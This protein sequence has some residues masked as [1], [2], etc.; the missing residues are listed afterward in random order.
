MGAARDFNYKVALASGLR[1]LQGG[2]L[3]QAEEQFR[4]LVAKFPA[5]D[6]GYRGLAKV[7]VELGDPKAALATLRQGAA[8]CAKATERPAAIALLREAVAL[9]PLDVTSHRHLAATLALAGQHGAAIDEVA[10]YA[11]AATAAGRLDRAQLE[12]AY[13]VERFPSD[14]ALHELRRR[15]G[16]SVAV[17]PVGPIDA[18]AV[19][20]ETLEIESDEADSVATAAASAPAPVELPPPVGEPAGTEERAAMLIGTRDPDAAQAALA[21]ARAHL[22]HGRTD[23]ASDLLLQVIAGGFADHRAQRMLVD[24]VRAMGRPEVARVKCKLL[25]QKLRLDGHDD[26]AGELELLARSV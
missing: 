2:R 16:V 5:A 18:S 24:V 17:A 22:D 25:A 12:V 20:M 23:A 15:F 4:Y 19:A 9:D 3:R 7:H 1:D 8:A 10:R 26:L 14:D 11:D 13:A 6:G 21:A